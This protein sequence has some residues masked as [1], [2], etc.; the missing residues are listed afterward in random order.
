MIT[1][2]S[3]SASKNYC[4]LFAAVPGVKK[5]TFDGRSAYG[6]IGNVTT[7][8]PGTPV[9]DKKATQGD[10]A[11]LDGKSVLVAVVE[12][13]APGTTASFLNSLKIQF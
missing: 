2:S 6:V 11:V 9:S 12:T 10:L 4:K 8:N 7:L 1:F 5:E 3:P 13:K